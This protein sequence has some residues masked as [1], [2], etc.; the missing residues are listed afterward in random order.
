MPAGNAHDE[1]IRIPLSSAAASTV[2]VLAVLFTLYIARPLLLPIAIALL[3]N[4]LFAP[5]VRRLSRLGLPDSLGAAFV[6]GLLIAAFI[7][8]GASLMDPA[9]DWL[10]HA[11]TSVR[12]LSREFEQVKQPL[13]GIKKLSEEVTEMTEIK[14][15]KPKPPAVEIDAP[16]AL[17]KVMNA[18]P[19]FA[20]GLAV[21]LLTTFF[22][23][24][25]GDRRARRLLAFGRTWSVKR[26]MI[27]I[28]REIQSEIS[29]H[30]R[31][32]TLINVALG[33]AVGFV[34]WL[35]DV[36][37]PALWGTMVALLNFAPYLGAIVGAVVLTVV[38]AA[39]FDGL[40]HALVVPGSFLLLTAVEGAV[41]TPLVLGRRLSLNPLVVFLS[42]IFW[43][44]IWGIAGALIAVPLV[45]TL[46]VILT[47]TPRTKAVAYMLGS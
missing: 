25:G 28:M 29:R 7:A 41:I 23:L 27:L 34:M 11:P 4:L 8:A 47:H 24:A 16:N 19:A 14:T 1:P 42:V 22:L 36:P 15:D 6:V 3:L 30:L 37:N 46:K 13:E 40:W 5:L 31:T 38:G 20:A 21:T 45:S 18:I 32:V 10:E 12:E 43:G 2:A 26:S 35:I 44:W 17:D 39:T 9:R 33:A